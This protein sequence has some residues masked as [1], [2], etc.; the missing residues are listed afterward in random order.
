MLPSLIAKSM[1]PLIEKILDAL[2]EKGLMP[3]DPEIKSIIKKLKLIEF[4][5]DF[6][7]PDAIFSI[8][9]TIASLIT[10]F[11]LSAVIFVA[12]NNFLH[13]TGIYTLVFILTTPIVIYTMFESLYRKFY[14][15]KFK[16]IQDKLSLEAYAFLSELIVRLSYMKPLDAI[17][18]TFENA[19]DRLKE[20]YKIHMPIIE[21]IL[22]RKEEAI[23][24]EKLANLTP[25][26]HFREIFNK[27]AE[28]KGGDY[29]EALLGL[30]ESMYTEWVYKKDSTLS[31]IKG[32]VPWYSMGWGIVAMLLTLIELG[33]SFIRTNPL[34]P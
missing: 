13:I 23:A 24:V 34:A 22:S 11:I 2:V 26:D 15:S 28:V 10:A 14:I 30:K 9:N 16:E 19:K 25:S 29:T 32:I 18:S 8:A 12:I 7:S 27:I 3:E 33:L 20:S 31:K 5:S 4:E 21:E 6:Y 17:I 1:K